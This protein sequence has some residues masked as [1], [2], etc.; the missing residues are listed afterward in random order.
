MSNLEDDYYITTFKRVT[1]IGHLLLM[2]LQMTNDE[3]DKG[4]IP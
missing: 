2:D 1:A 4:L 3:N